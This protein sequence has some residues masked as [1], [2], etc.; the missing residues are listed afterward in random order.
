MRVLYADN[1]LLTNVATKNVLK[2]PGPHPLS[3]KNI[4]SKLKIKKAGP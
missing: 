1:N 4:V 2:N 3:I